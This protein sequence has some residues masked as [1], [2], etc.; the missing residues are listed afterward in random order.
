[1][2]ST[3][4]CISESGFQLLEQDFGVA[5]DDHQQV[6]EVVG[7][8]ARQA[9]DGFHFL[10]LP[11]LFFQLAALGNVLGDQFQN[12]FPLLGAAGGA[13]AEPHRDRPSVLVFPLHFRAVQAIPSADIL[14]SSGQFPGG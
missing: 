13:A 10:R 5:V 12:F 8:A 14:R 9:P 4:W 3:I 11:E 2:D 7:D 6:V 1:M